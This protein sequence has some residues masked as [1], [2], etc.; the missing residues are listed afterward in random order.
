MFN[1]T[2]SSLKFNKITQRNSSINFV[3]GLSF[4]VFLITLVVLIEEH[5]WLEYCVNYMYKNNK[6]NFIFV[7]SC[8]MIQTTK[9]TK[10]KQLC[11]IIHCSL[12]A[13]HVSSDIFAHDQEQLNCMHRESNTNTIIIRISFFSFLKL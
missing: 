11:R 1:L 3:F 4:C 2:I 12:S 9:M 8:I 10:K 5:Q 7:V 13:L 6:I